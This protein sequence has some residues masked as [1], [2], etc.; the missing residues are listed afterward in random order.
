M[1]NAVIA[2]NLNIYTYSYK[3]SQQKQLFFTT[4]KHEKTNLAVISIC[5]I[6]SLFS[7]F[8][9]QYKKSNMG[10][11]ILSYTFSFILAKTQK[12]IWITFVTYSSR[13]PANIRSIKHKETHV[14]VQK[15]YIQLSGFGFNKTRFLYQRN[16]EQH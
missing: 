16:D 15:N 4:T 10:H 2:R 3:K 8:N 7:T 13:F 11:D 1:W 5:L 12:S 9:Q 14:H 6:I